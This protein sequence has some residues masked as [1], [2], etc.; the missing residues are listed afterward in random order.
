MPSEPLLRM[1][2]Q[3]CVEPFEQCPSQIL[4]MLRRGVRFQTQ[5]RQQDHAH[6]CALAD[7]R[8]WYHTRSGRSRESS[9][10]RIQ[11]DLLSAE[12]HFELGLRQF[13]PDLAEFENL[14]G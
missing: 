13:G 11:V 3:Q 4:H 5:G 6:A 9:D 14:G 10:P 12:C 8:R 7:Q 2:A 1:A